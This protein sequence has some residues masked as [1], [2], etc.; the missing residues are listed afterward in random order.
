MI[1][2][3]RT[4]SARVVIVSLMMSSVYAQDAVPTDDVA[5]IAQRCSEES[6]PCSQSC[7]CADA[8]RCRTTGCRGCCQVYTQDQELNKSGSSTC[9]ASYCD[10]SSECSQENLC[11]GN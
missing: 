11:C 7:R 6:C 5:E 8:C 3:V 10:C 9:V 4:L 1:H 2:T